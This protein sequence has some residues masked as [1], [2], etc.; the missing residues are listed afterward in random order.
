M[1]IALPGVAA[2][3]TVTVQGPSVRFTFS[4]KGQ[5]AVRMRV[6]WDIDKPPVVHPLPSGGG[7]QPQP[8]QIAP[9]RYLVSARVQAVALP[10]LPNASIDSE[11][12]INGQRVLTAKGLLPTQEPRVD[13]DGRMFFLVVT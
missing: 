10:G 4:H 13:L 9:G 12:S 5:A 1:Q 3:G 11:L 6:T 8:R 7:G 2:D